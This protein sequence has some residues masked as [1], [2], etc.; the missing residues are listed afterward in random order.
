[1]EKV[2]LDWKAP[3]DGKIKEVL[4]KLNDKEKQKEF[5]K[6]CIVKKNEKNIIDKTKAKHWIDDNC[7]NYVEWKN[8]PKGGTAK[9]T[10]IADEIASWLDL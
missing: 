10:T 7:K 2:I 5:A 4:L 8:Y 3:T 1:M 9:R 6:E